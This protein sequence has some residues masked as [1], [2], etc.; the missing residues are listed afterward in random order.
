VAANSWMNRPG[1]F[2]VRGGKLV[3]VRPFQVFFNGAFGYEAVHMLLAAYVVAGFLVAGVYAAG[4]LKGRRDRYHRV[5]FLIAFTVAAAVMPVQIFVG[6]IAARQVFHHE[7]AKFAAIELLPRGSSHVPET[8]GGVL[9]GGKVRY[10][11]RIPD[12][13]SLLAGFSP[14]TRITGLD[15]VPPATRPRPDL[16]TTVHLAFD[17]MVGTA[18]ALL[19]MAVWFALGWWRRRDLPRSVWFLRGAAIAG[20]VSVVS[21]EAGWVVTEVGR[22]PW[23]VVGLLLT[24]DAVTTSGDVWWFF[25]GTLVIYA[26]VGAAAVIVL[27]RMGQGWATTPEDDPGV[28]YGPASQPEVLAG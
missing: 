5:G 7:P 17:A 23:T 24:R 22:Q 20:V 14:G 1:G 10:G 21:L 8:L 4:M 16:V 18:F 12:G 2:T 6:D 13:A 25:G 9:I 19:G 27:R 28:P 11:L 3:D 15:A 26:A